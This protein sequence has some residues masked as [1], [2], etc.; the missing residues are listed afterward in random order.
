MALN[1]MQ[2]KKQSAVR[3]AKA[4]VRPASIAL[5]QM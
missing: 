2:R 4:F 3:L 5:G 1:A